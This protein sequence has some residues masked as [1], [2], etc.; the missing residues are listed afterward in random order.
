M[1]ATEQRWASELANFDITLEYKSGK[2]NKSADG[3][4]R[5]VER[6]WDVSNTE[7]LELCHSVLDGTPLP[8]ALQSVMLEQ[9][10][11]ETD[12]S[13]PLSG[14]TH[15]TA[16]PKMTKKKMEEFQYNDPVI[17][18]V[19]K[20]VKKTVKPS[21][22]VIKFSPPEVKLLIRQWN[23]LK[24]INNLLYRVIL[25]PSHGEFKQLVLPRVLR[26]DILR[27]MHEE[28]GH[29]G[30]DHTASLIR[31]KCY[32]PICT[33]TFKNGSSIAI[34]VSWQKKAPRLKIPLEQ[35][36]PANP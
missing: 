26:E 11:E 3:L 30:T 23:K 32:C 19:L 12:D 6:P 34:D 20:H 31:S 21:Y 18:E 7:V 28:H 10:V 9:L 2:Q 17:S 33:V 22:A 35:F 27:H 14:I 8:I 25:D 36:R 29:Q 24:I 5:Q 4:L 15:A 13:V 16:L 1:S